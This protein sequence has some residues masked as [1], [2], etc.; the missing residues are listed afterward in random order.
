MMLVCSELVDLG[1]HVVS[2][3]HWLRFFGADVVLRSIRYE[4]LSDVVFLDAVA[5]S[6]EICFGGWY[7]GLS[8]LTA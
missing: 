2:T 8:G 4:N 7:V 6:T 5:R 1:R 3:S